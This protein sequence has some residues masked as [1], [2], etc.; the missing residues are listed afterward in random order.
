MPA[1]VIVIGP[2]DKR[3]PKG[4]VV[5]NTTSR[6]NDF[7]KELSPFFLGPVRLYD[8]IESKNVEN[9]W[10]YSKVYAEHVGEDGLPTD[11]WATWAYNGFR[12]QRADRYPM[13]KGAVPE[14]SFWREE[15]LSYIEA[16]RRIYIP[17]YAKSVKNTEAFAKLRR[18][19][20]ELDTLYLWD[21]DGYDHRA[22]GLTLLE[23]MNR[24]DLKM[25]HGFVLAMMLQ[26]GK[27]F[28]LK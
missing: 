25:G 12:K 15:K 16:R 10:Q 22:K 9:A 23:V 24:P 3:P 26:F 7:G 1:K 18:L 5:I 11:R 14:F 8:G 27:N 17:L 13:G 4:E 28:Y 6:S 20:R 19:Y 2:R 21:F